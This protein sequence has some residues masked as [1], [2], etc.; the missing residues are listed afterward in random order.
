MNKE[1]LIQR[2]LKADEELSLLVEDKQRIKVVI[3]GGSAL[4][5]NNVISRST[6]DID[7]IGLYQNLDAAFSKYD[8]NSMS[9]SFIDSLAENYDSRLVKLELKTKVLDYYTLSIEDLVIMK[10]HSSR[11][12]DYLDATNEEVI[13]TLNW[14][15][16]EKIVD[17]GELDNTFNERK[18]KEFLNKFNEYIKEYK[19]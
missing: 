18:Y 9:N 10:L 16:L 11:K 7:V 4:I 17:D 2:L 8:I 12:K 1:E 3:V 6:M 15:L 13:K 14:T 19:K 5:I